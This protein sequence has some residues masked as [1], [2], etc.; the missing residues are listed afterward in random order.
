MDVLS[1]NSINTIGIGKVNDLFD[2][3]G[4]KTVEKTKS[5]EE[6][7]QKII[8]YA[9]KSKNSLIFAN[10]VDFDVYYGHRNDPNGFYDALKS[11]DNLLPQLI[12]VL[13]DSD[14]LVYNC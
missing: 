11:F 2:Y 3:R 4:I 13:D 10:L 7:F 12:D 8:E 9:G 6:G 1:K 14:A 5:N